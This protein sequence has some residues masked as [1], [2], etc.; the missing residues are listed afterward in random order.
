MT[1]Y[2]GKLRKS[3]RQISFGQTTIHRSTSNRNLEVNESILISQKRIRRTK[4]K[5]GM[6]IGKL[7]L[8]I[9]AKNII[10]RVDRVCEMKA[11]Q[12]YES[13]LPD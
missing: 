3:K 1:K 6:E 12:K 7:S 10:L 4:E 8:H 9:L 13:N 5:V 2:L 11:A